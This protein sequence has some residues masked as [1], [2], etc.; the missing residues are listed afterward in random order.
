MKH[1][2][3]NWSKVKERKPRK[4]LDTIGCQTRLKR[5]REKCKARGYRFDLMSTEVLDT[6]NYPK[7]NASRDTDELESD[8]FI[9]WEREPTR[10]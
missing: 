4:C 3:R 8:L 7:L 5:L 10:Y 9:G 6:R 1:I 2:T